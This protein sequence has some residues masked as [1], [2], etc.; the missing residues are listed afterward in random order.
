M[1]TTDE[2]DVLRFV[3]IPKVAHPWFEEV[4]RGAVMQAELLQ[5]RVGGRIEVD[6]LPPA[7]AD[8]AEQGA[9]LARACATDP[10]GIA[11][12]PLDAIANLPAMAAA[13]ERGIPVV[14]FDS[15]APDPAVPSIGNDYVLQGRIAARRLIDLIGGAGEVAIMQGVPA[16][17]NH[18]QRYEAQ[19]D[20]LRRHPA[21]TIVDGGIDHDDIPTARREAAAVLAARPALRGYLCCDAS[22]PI[23]IADAVRQA[24]RVG[25][26]AVVGMDGLE[27]ILEAIE[28]GVLDSSSATIP[29]M[30]G[31]M[32]LLMLWEASQGMRIPQQVDTGIDVITSD[33][34]DG[35]LAAL[36]ARRP[37]RDAGPGGA[38]RAA[39]GPTTVPA[40]PTVPGS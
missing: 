5:R 25:E 26:V 8:L 13:R 21:I 28:E 32:A 22:G 12:D 11:I 16:A 31:S 27:P 30:Q 7:R 17:P 23:G 38:G 35:F 15:P 40:D 37:S 4:R 34:V 29:D 33:N 9:M 3:I 18:R 10:A 14:V 36:R 2:S 24:G 20:E 39:G 6:Y 19:R 1:A